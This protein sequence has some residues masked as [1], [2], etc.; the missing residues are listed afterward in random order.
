MRTLS[1]RQPWL[2]AVFHAEKTLENRE[3]C[4]KGPLGPVL[5]HEAKECTVAEYEWAATWMET[6]ELA[7]RSAAIARELSVPV[8][9]PLAELPRRGGIVGRAIVV[10]RVTPLGL[11]D[12]VDRDRLARDDSELALDLRWHMRGD[13]YG[14]VLRDVTACAFH[15]CRGY[16][17]FFES[18]ETRL[19]FEGGAEGRT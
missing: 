7:H 6:R 8:L 11:I 19:L 4:W 17:W 15:P 12:V 9:P 1:L 13:H 10:G 5:L 16:P 3:T 2:W 18:D 14:Y